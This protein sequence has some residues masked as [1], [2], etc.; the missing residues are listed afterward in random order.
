MAGAGPLHTQQIIGAQT[1]TDL[2]AAEQELYEMPYTGVWL[3]Q[4]H[5]E[6]EELGE[7]GAVC[8]EDGSLKDGEQG[9]PRLVRAA[10]VLTAAPVDKIRFCTM[11]ENAWQ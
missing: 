2:E 10:G 6:H 7:L 11:S 1:H 3:L 4:A 5:V 9:L 8:V